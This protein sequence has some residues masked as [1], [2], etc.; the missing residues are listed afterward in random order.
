[1]AADPL[2]LAELLR[3]PSSSSGE[4][5]ASLFI[6]HGLGD[7]ARGWAPPGRQLAAAF[8]GLHVILPTAPNQPVT[9]NGGARCPSWY[10]IYGLGADDKIDIEG[11]DAAAAAIVP[12]MEAEA[13][14][15]GWENVGL[16]GFSQGGVVTL[17]VMLSGKVP[18]IGAFIALSAY[19]P[20][21]FDDHG[22]P[23]VDDS[24]AADSS[25]RTPLFHGHGD[26][27]MVVKYEWGKATAD[28]LTSLNLPLTFETYEGMGHSLCDLELVDIK[29][30]VRKHLIRDDA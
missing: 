20:R 14:K 29:A 12:L 21:S 2:E 3:Y 15:V 18:K 11:L 9:I 26:F 7:S 28:L 24:V 1:M 6:V 30:F 27:D 4:H 23:S 8:P 17:H 16:M 22:I 19:L 25:L 5:R 13:E 10:D